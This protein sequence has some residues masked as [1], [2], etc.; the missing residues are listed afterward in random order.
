MLRIAGRAVWRMRG[1]HET[2]SCCWGPG[3]REGG[4]GRGGNVD[5][6]SCRTVDIACHNT[7]AVAIY[8]CRSSGSGTRAFLGDFS[9][10][11]GRPNSCIRAIS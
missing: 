11:Q 10:A 7:N 9:E 8:S 3:E 4:G 2:Q 5:I 1:Q 6:M